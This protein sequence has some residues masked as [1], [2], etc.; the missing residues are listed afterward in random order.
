MADVYSNYGKKDRYSAVL[1]IADLNTRTPNNWSI[2]ATLFQKEL[3]SYSGRNGDGYRLVMHFKDK[4]GE[5][6]TVMFGGGNADGLHELH[7]SLVEGSVYRVSDGKINVAYRKSENPPPKTRK[8]RIPRVSEYE[9]VLFLDK[10]SITEAKKTHNNSGPQCNMDHI[11]TLK[12]MAEIGWDGDIVSFNDLVVL[13]VS[14]EYTGTT[15]SGDRDYKRLTLTLGDIR[16]KCAVEMTLWN[17]DTSKAGSLSVGDFVS[18]SD[19]LVNM[20]NGNIQLKLRSHSIFQKVSAMDP[21]PRVVKETVWEHLSKMEQK[22]KE[23]SVNQACGTGSVPVASLTEVKDSVKNR[24]PGTFVLLCTVCDFPGTGAPIYNSCNS[25]GCKS[26]V[27]FDEMTQL[28]TCTKCS[29]HDQVCQH[30]YKLDMNI[31][32]EQGNVAKC[33]AFGVVPEN[34]FDGKPAQALSDMLVQDQDGTM[35]WISDKEYEFMCEPSGSRK[36]YVLTARAEMEGSD[37][38]FYPKDK[39]GVK[40]ESR[41]R[42]TCVFM[43]TVEDAAVGDKVMKVLTGKEKPDCAQTEQSKMVH[44]SQKGLKYTPYTGPSLLKLWSSSS[45]ET[46][47]TGETSNSKR[48]R[49]SPVGLEVGTL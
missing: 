6:K 37:N 14:E 46:S 8:E 45:N 33:T 36:K 32:D 30:K 4:T 38:D 35:T 9:A 49:T 27:S 10:S 7:D 40:N 43:E 1:H 13:E 47:Q 31:A 48:R 18:L 17:E 28:W 5:L 29:K 26:S 25:K 15:K 21:N 23:N 11:R 2:E 44:R 34:I 41:L 20:Y 19:A 42:L 3:L 39:Y 12:Q 16:T 24:G 22:Q